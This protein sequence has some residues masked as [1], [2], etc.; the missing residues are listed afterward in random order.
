MCAMKIAI[1]NETFGPQ[2]FDQAFATCRRLGYTGIEMAPF[3][4][5]P[6]DD[7]FDVRKVP[8]SQRAEVR[9]QAADAGLE[10]VGLHWLLAKTQGIYLTSP[11]PAVRKETTDYLVALVEFCADLGGNVMVLGSPQQRNLLPGVSYGEA[12]KYAAEIIA[13]A[14]P[15]CAQHGVRIALEPLTPHEGDFLNTAEQAMTLAGLVDSEHCQLHLDCKAMTSEEDSIPEL[16][17]RHQ[18]S[19]IHF[20]ANDP[21]LL[22]PGMGDLDFLPIVEALEKIDYQHWVSV[23][24]FRYEPSP[25]EIAR[26]S[27]DHLRKIEQQLASVA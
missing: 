13:G 25:E 17:D 23:E 14:M 19:M 1:C 2:P 6:D 9:R 20:H 21:N 4:L 27:Y 8:A 24:V 5:L 16:V 7:P 26:V 15:A 18:Q 12:E 11:E 10:V 3:T 22:G